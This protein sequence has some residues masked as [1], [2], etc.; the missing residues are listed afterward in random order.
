MSTIQIQE[1]LDTHT[2][3]KDVGIFYSK[4]ET[5]L[6]KKQ[7]LVNRKLVKEDLLDLSW[8]LFEDKKEDV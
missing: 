2:A 5:S 8:V 6:L 3:R 4:K 7:R 1:K